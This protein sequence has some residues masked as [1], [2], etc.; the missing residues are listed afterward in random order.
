[1]SEEISREEQL[2]E[3]IQQLITAHANGKVDVSWLEQLLKEYI[4]LSKR[5]SKIL[6]MGDKQ[7]EELTRKNILLED[8]STKLSF[9]LSPQ[10]YN[11]IFKGTKDATLKSERKKLT[12]FFSDLVNFTQTTEN[13]EPEMLSDILNNY[14]DEMITIALKYGATVDKFI[15]DAIM[16]FFG[17]PETKGEKEDALACISMA[18]EMRSKMD[19]LSKQWM[20]KGLME[21]LK[22]RMGMTTGYVTVGNFGSRHRMDYTIIGGQVNLASRLEYNANP[23]TILISHE[24]YSLIKK[25][26]FCEKKDT[27]YVKGIPYPIMTYEVVNYFKHIKQDNAI[28]ISNQNITLYINKDKLAEQKNASEVLEFLEESIRQIKDIHQQ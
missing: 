6:R 3:N 23:N 15:G 9:Y 18:L 27:I 4:K 26:V 24:T 28:S 20:E 22:V 12:I 19:I 17:D 5:I 1:M 11:S 2:I 14:L 16:V 7:Q 25:E 8:L 21:P 10:I 13:L